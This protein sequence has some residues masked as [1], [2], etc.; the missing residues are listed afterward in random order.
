MN[1]RDTVDIG[2]IASPIKNG[3]A[4]KNMVLSYYNLTTSS[5]GHG[6][7]LGNIESDDPRR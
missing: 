2:D 6:V 5:V 7:N 1:N 3:E 4:R